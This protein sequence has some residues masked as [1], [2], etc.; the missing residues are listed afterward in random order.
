[1]KKKSVFISLHFVLI[2]V[3]WFLLTTT[4]TCA[5]T[6]ALSGSSY[7]T[8]DE[9][10][11]NHEYN[12]E[13]RSIE[14]ISEQELG[15]SETTV[16][17]ITGISLDKSSVSMPVGDSAILTANILPSD[18]DSE[19]IWDSSNTDNVTVDSNGKVT[20][21]EPG[22][23]VITATSVTDDT[24]S[25]SCM[26][27]SEHTVT[28]DVGPHGKSPDIQMVTYNCTV[29]RP[30]EPEAD[31]YRFVDWCTSA[32]TVYDFETP[33]FDDLTLYAQWESNNSDNSDSTYKLQ[34]AYGTDGTVS[35]TGIT[36]TA[37]GSLIIPSVEPNS[38]FEVVGIDDNAFYGCY[39][40]TGELIIP[41]SIRRIG[42]KAFWDCGGF[43]GTLVIPEGVTS[44]G[45][46]AF[47]CNG[48]TEF[49]NNSPV[50]VELPQVGIEWFDEATGEI[51]SGDSV[52]GGHTAIRCDYYK[53][54][55]SYDDVNR[56]A[57][58][59]GYEYFPFYETTGMPKVDL[60][61]PEE[62]PERGYS[63]TRI[64][65]YAFY[66][67]DN[68]TG[69][70]IPS[71][72]SEIGRNAFNNCNFGHVELS[73]GLVTIGQDAF[74]GCSGLYRLSIPESVEY[75]GDWA[76]ADCINLGGNLTI[77]GSV[78]TIGSCAFRGCNKINGLTI[79]E[80]VETISSG[81]FSDCTGMKGDLII[82]D[83]VTIIAGS[84]FS[85]CSGF[86]GNLVVGS[87]VTTIG[88]F[89]FD[90]CSGFARNLSLPNAMISIG[91]YAFNGC[92]GFTGGIRIPNSVTKI[93]NRAFYGCDGFD[94][95]LEIGCKVES[96][97]ASAFEGCSNLK[98]DL[99]IP[100]SVTTIGNNAF[101]RC[102]GFTGTLTIPKHLTEI[103]DYVFN[104]C[105]GLT[106]SLKIPDNVETIGKLAF[107][108]CNK[109]TG[110]LMIPDSAKTIGDFAFNGCS[111]F[112]G[113]LVIPK[114]VTTISNNALFGCTGLTRVVN[115]SYQEVE[116]PQ[117]NGR[118]WKN[119][120]TGEEVT[121]IINGTAI[122]DDFTIKFVTSVNLN[123]TAVSLRTGSLSESK[124]EYTIVTDVLPE[125]ATDRRVEFR[126]VKDSDSAYLTVTDNGNGTATLTPTGS[127][128]VGKS[129][130][131]VSVIAKAK[132]GSNKSATC[133]VTLLAAVEGL[134]LTGPT[135][136]RLATGKSFTVK[137]VFNGNSTIP[138]N[139]NLVWSS[140]DSYVATVSQTGSVS[141]KNPG[142][143]TITAYSAD[144]KGTIND[145]CTVRVYEPVTKVAF[146]TSKVSVGSGET[147]TIRAT[148]TPAIRD[149]DDSYKGVE[150]IS[151]D[152]SV[153][154]ITGQ[155]DGTA[156]VK[157][158]LPVGATRKSVKIT[159]RSK[160]GSNKTAV[161]TV[162]IGKGAD[163]ISITAPKN[164]NTI[165]V[166]S[167][168][169][170]TATT[171]PKDAVNKNVAWIS[172]DSNVAT[173]DAKGIVRAV[174]A[175][176]SPVTITAANTTNNGIKGT[177]TI[178][179]TYIPLKSIKLNA[180]SISLHA[181]QSYTIAP[182][183]TPKNATNGNSTT[184]ETVIYEVTSGEDYIS[185]DNNGRVTAGSEE[186]LGNKASQTA[187][188]SVTA[189]SDGKI[190]KTAV[191][192]VKVTKSPVKVSSV[193]LSATRLAM[194]EGTQATI[195]ATIAPVTADEQALEW[196]SNNENIATV[197]KS[198][199]VVTIKAISSGTTKITATA[200]D[201]S[202]KSA[203]CTV[204]VGNPVA[205]VKLNNESLRVAV[206]KTSTLKATLTDSDGK[207]LANTTVTWTSD[208]PNIATVS[209]KGVVKAVSTGTAK[210]IATAEISSSEG[211]KT[212]SCTVTTYVPVKKI[213][214]NRTSI[215]I[216]EGGNTEIALSVLTPSDA[217]DKKINWIS[218]NTSV[219]KITNNT[220]YLNETDDNKRAEMLT[221]AAQTDT[222]ESLYIYAAG[223][224]TAKI[225]GVANDGSNKKVTITAR[226]AGIMKKD[227]VKLD[228]KS[229]PKG[230]TLVPE[231]RNTATLNVSALPVK[232]TVNLVPVL[233]PTAVVKN[234]TYRSSN[235]NVATVDK[236]GKITAK[237][238]GMAT[239]T[240]R[241]LD[242]GYEAT[243]NITV[244]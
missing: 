117:T 35:V 120:D 132:D 107:S 57:T 116:L 195:N 153:A 74:M 174:A 102:R 123:S 164:Q 105:S 135:D 191:C 130:V 235:Q 146:D 115:C 180:T 202:K 65:D 206:G 152:S 69:I 166:G 217:T 28:F 101:S 171:L 201:G 12:K 158:T 205:S 109:L 72:V 84:S 71:S 87:G 43:T 19:V 192:T 151:A 66:Y 78:K 73:D 181:G 193:K 61:I 216:R 15:A 204:T 29:T 37:S 227:D 226:V 24:I 124:E 7:V 88:D 149:D 189:K 106:G 190:T 58:V 168:L 212:A 1:M 80:G 33:V 11:N 218:S 207:K 134:S 219:V 63:V 179:S 70:T 13:G 196:E 42:S 122:R 210:I 167:T 163:S 211:P 64:A 143:V 223:P 147:F 160:D 203:V 169:K 91:D 165:A 60:I 125:S 56:T 30:D 90:G 231:S 239:I 133:K 81:A 224:G 67:N 17:P 194:G 209:P 10:Q 23:S 220:S 186:S 234:V 137:P 233:T 141:A 96:I 34:Y 38:G 243:C 50:S 222:G 53:L 208:N 59:T 94:C 159:A 238:S 230:V 241:T 136:G 95:G 18:A 27:T 39:G 170:L 172:S 82:P 112:T 145:S 118:L 111:R 110:N 52:A 32:G 176:T 103:G 5:M 100:D 98:W 36:G 221:G 40:F 162:N 198:D 183:I 199:G 157:A 89:A 86:T 126:L 128:P 139:K 114:S 213:T 62:D 161:C 148:E 138:S 228:V 31:G 175:S 108:G 68:F 229:I 85:G 155:S 20:M 113:T 144:G 8:M 2:I 131:T 240:M 93:G 142:T 244:P 104:G 4:D 200:T 154:E 236:N 119:I 14:S 83:S 48:I 3:G 237:A 215:N 41:S 99:T 150:F 185:V 79:A 127:M 16:I 46:C 76:F 173:V 47:S 156:I 140:S 21:V 45:D 184:K 182:T 225:T 49:I 121:S 129:S 188:V 26:V 214:V 232:K 55:F 44:I 97:G 51:I 77:P 197:T 177:Y 54:K 178:D 187:K 6:Y 242:G 92:K 75:I 22:T 25:T 9:L